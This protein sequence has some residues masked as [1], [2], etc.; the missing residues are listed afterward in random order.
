MDNFAASPA[1]FIIIAII[2]AAGVALSLVLVSKA[3]KSVTHLG[4]VSPMA[5]SND[6]A[7]IIGL[8][9]TSMYINDLPVLELVVA[10][11]PANGPMETVSCR[12]AFTYVDIPQLVPGALVYVIYSRDKK[13]AVKGLR[14][15][16]IRPIEWSGDPEAIAAV[17]SLVQGLQGM[18]LKSAQGTILSTA[19]S[20]A[21]VN[22]TPVYKYR[23]SFQTPEGRRI[24]GDTY[25]AARPWLCDC[26]AANPAVTVQF[27]AVDPE[28]FALGKQ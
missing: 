5:A 9:Q 10:V 23:V 8:N 20:G 24:E 6:S 11:F 4:G 26:R 21:I 27:S 12:Q 17:N 2:V 15:Q 18:S 7:Y 3:R 25:Q 19:K 13:G 28:K 16:G 1:F 14:V 22:G